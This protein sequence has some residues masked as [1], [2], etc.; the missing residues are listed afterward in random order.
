MPKQ[1]TLTE[2][3]KK[4][5]HLSQKELIALIAKLYKTNSDA[6]NI[7]NVE[8]GDASY[9]DELLEESKQKIQNIFFPERSMAFPSLSKA[10]KII[11]DFKKASNSFGGLI[12]LKVY[13]AECVAEFG[14]AYGDMP[15]SFYDSLESVYE[16]VVTGL[17][18]MNSESLFA[19]YYERLKAIA[20]STGDM[21]YGISEALSF[22]LYDDLGWEPK[23]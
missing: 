16:D 19:K 8:L 6:V 1:M 15:E 22:F 12:E 5:S 20:D 14:N 2:V 4:L 3:K 11:S 9:T 10:K 13:Y 7:L 18:K 21:G 23:E 17:N